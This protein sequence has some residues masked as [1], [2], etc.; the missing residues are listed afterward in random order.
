[1]RSWNSCVAG[2]NWSRR[3]RRNL[4][5]KL[6][7]KPIAILRVRFDRARKNGCYWILSCHVTFLSALTLTRARATRSGVSRSASRSAVCRST[8][9]PSSRFSAT[10]RRSAWRTPS[11]TR[12]ARVTTIFKSSQS[13]SWIC[14][15]CFS[16][17]DCAAQHSHLLL[18]PFPALRD[19]AHCRCVL[20]QAWLRPSRFESHFVIKPGSFP[21]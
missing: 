17:Q 12:Q 16:L 13:S 15:S 6:T 4:L 1:M 21:W 5:A 10:T 18:L 14:M 7:R 2:C 3:C 11:C 8:E 19:R 9:D 20:L